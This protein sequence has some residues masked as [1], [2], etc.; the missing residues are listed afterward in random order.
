MGR[1][2][3]GVNLEQMLR[4]FPT[5][6]GSALCHSHFP[7]VI[8]DMFSFVISTGAPVGAKWRNLPRLCD[9]RGVAEDLS[10]R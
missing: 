2:P 10:T 9:P 1:F 5:E 6:G 4:V 3:R 7:F 8:L